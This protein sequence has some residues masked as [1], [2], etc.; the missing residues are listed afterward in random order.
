MSGSETERRSGA[1]SLWQ[2]LRLALPWVLLLASLALFTW[3][4]RTVP[5][6]A[7]DAFISYR[8]ARNLVQGH[9]LVYNPGERVEGYTNLLWTLLLSAGLASGLRAQD[10]AHLLSLASGLGALFFA[11]A[12]ARAIL[13]RALVWLAGFA[14]LLLLLSP[15]FAVW[16]CS[17]LETPLFT[18]TLTAALAAEAR[19]SSGW[20]TAA[21][22]VAALTRPE[23]ALAAAVLYALHLYRQR[24]RPLAALRPVLLFSSL[25]V[26]L[27]L[28]RLIYYDAWLPNTYYA[29]AGGLPLQSGPLYLLGWLLSG[30]AI[31][32]VM[33][34]PAARRNSL[35]H[36]GATL[37]LAF[38][39]YAVCIGGDVFNQWRFLLPVLPALIGLGLLGCACAFEMHPALGRLCTACLGATAL[40]FLFGSGASAAMAVLAIAAALYAAIRG[41][42]MRPA[43]MALSTLLV[44]SIILLPM[45]DRW[46]DRQI[47]ARGIAAYTIGISRARARVENRNMYRLMHWSARH[48]TRKIVPRCPYGCLVASVSIGM[49]GFYSHLPIVDVLGIV[50]PVI[51][52]SRVRPQS[53]KLVLLPGHQ[54]TD[55]DYVLARRPDF[56][57]VGTRAEHMLP[58]SLELLDHPG[59]Q[60]DY[61]FDAK[62]IG[63][64]RRGRRPGAR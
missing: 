8:Y 5:P 30:P 24:Q 51:S 32:A 43:G 58:A 27:T 56:I 19:R 37:T 28:F 16:S 52:R 54:K 23:G 7:D 6:Q 15:S 39:I 33:A 18:A 26:A 20:M 45:V 48:Y 60:R 55:A 38:C 44:G 35:A 14:P 2:R 1:N 4:M 53:E 47:E 61:I 50:D 41:A 13:P 21:L 10:T 11:F 64:V 59:F 3:E 12:Y 34:T 57:L 22:A 25:L 49:L 46:L 9:G 62:L 36:S 42:G 63:Y 29:K 40:F 17:G 31:L